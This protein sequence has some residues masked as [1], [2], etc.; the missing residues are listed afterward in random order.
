[1]GKTCRRLPV[2]AGRACSTPLSD[3]P[4][5]TDLKFLRPRGSRRITPGADACRAEPRSRAELAWTGGCSPQSHGCPEEYLVSQSHSTA[6]PRRRSL[7]RADYLFEGIAVVG[8]L[9]V[10]A[11]AAAAS[12][13]GLRQVAEMTAGLSPELSWTVP[14]TIDGLSAVGS[15]VTLVMTR[16]G[17]RV[18]Y[19]WSVV[20]GTAVVSAAANAVSAPDGNLV[21][22]AVL[23]FL[24]L[25]LALALH[26]LL[27]LVSARLNRADD[28][29]A[30]VPV[31]VSP[32]P[33]LVPTSV[34]SE[35]APVAAEA[36]PAGLPLDRPTAEQIAAAAA[37]ADA[38]PV[39]EPELE[40]L[41]DP[42]LE[43]HLEVPAN[44]PRTPGGDLDLAALAH[45]AI[46]EL[47]STGRIVGEEEWE[48]VLAHQPLLRQYA[49]PRRQISGRITTWRKAQGLDRK[50][51]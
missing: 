42:A 1:M 43:R 41:P 40:S 51:A 22:M 16:I 28:R 13:H 30:G 2:C 12:F 10:S 7:S 45:A 20:I 27:L 15:I 29:L 39:T 6:T 36:P 32:A 3:D 35:S 26:L 50:A 24:P 19:P 33:V 9:A 21:G 49:R 8:T 23:A 18:V 31:P 34:E 48:V 44:A 37:A 17:G 4:N 14:V 47:A 25:G 11:A 38:E 46:E 5:D